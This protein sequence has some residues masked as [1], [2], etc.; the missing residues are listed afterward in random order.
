M[1]TISPSGVLEHVSQTAVLFEIEEIVNFIAENYQRNSPWVDREVFNP[2]YYQKLFD[3]LPLY[4]SLFDSHCGYDKPIA[5]FMSTALEIGLFEYLEEVIAEQQHYNWIVLDDF[6]R[7][8]GFYTRQITFKRAAS[9][10]RYELTQRTDHLTQYAEELHRRYARL[11]VIRIDFGYLKES[12]KQID[13][14]TFYKHQELLSKSID[15]NSLFTNLAGHARSLEQAKDRG[16][17][18]HAVFYF[19]GDKHQKDNYLV[20]QIRKIWANITAEHGSIYSPNLDKEKYRK[21]GTLGVGMIHRDEQKEVDNAIKA[22]KYLTRPDKDQHLRMR[23]RGRRIFFSG[24][25]K[26]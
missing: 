13:V 24:I 6:V 15:V 23:P 14:S 25:K 18:C 5:I 1:L 2:D 26:K 20:E 7:L 21:L 19:K 4:F 11:L 9:D 16:Y 17:H 8:I 22:V 3:K 12:V 10:R